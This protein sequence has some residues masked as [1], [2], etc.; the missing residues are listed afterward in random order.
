MVWVNGSQNLRNIL[1]IGHEPDFADLPRIVV[2][3]QAPT[4]KVAAFYRPR[5]C[6]EMSCLSQTV[7]FR[8][9]QC[10]F[11]FITAITYPGLL[12]RHGAHNWEGPGALTAMTALHFLSERTRSAPWLSNKANENYVIYAG[13]CSTAT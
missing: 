6:D 13:E 9:S 8:L 11:R 3:V 5:R 10:A 1:K 7:F 4:G 2:Y 12:V